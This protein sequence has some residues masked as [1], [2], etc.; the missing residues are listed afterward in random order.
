ME[1][2]GGGESSGGDA[3]SILRG[4]EVIVI[5]MVAMVS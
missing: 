3:G 4:E 2:D 1:G 5:A